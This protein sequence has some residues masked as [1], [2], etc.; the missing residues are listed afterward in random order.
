MVFMSGFHAHTTC[1]ADRRPAAWVCLEG[2]INEATVELRVEP[3]P[4]AP[5]VARDGLLREE[6]RSGDHAQTAVRELLLLHDAELGGVLWLEVERVEAE[7]ARRV[8]RLEALERLRL[9]A[10]PRLLEVFLTRV[11]P[12]LVDAQI[13][14]ATRKPAPVVFS[15]FAI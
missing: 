4:R 1:P 8:V 7:V 2:G 5:R 13:V 3:P 11:R 12:A 15:M 6:A 14:S 10:R 9:A